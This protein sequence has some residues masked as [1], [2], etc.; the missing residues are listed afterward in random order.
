MKYWRQY[1]F[2]LQIFVEKCCK[3]NYS[4]TVQ[5]WDLDVFCVG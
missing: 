4:V 5:Y 3:R 2:H 1:D